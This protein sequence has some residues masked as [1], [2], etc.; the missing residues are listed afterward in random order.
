V[1][2]K[3]PGPLTPSAAVEAACR[4]DE[5]A[6]R[7][8]QTGGECAVGETLG[9]GVVAAERGHLGHAQHDGELL[10]RG[11]LLERR[12]AGR[13]GQGFH[14]LVAHAMSSE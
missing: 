14:I 3:Y 13:R 10:V 5:E 9:L 8:R 4:G 6:E 1:W 2:L 11:Q 7:L 12:Q